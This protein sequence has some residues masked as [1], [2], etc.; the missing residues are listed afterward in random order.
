MKPVT[1]LDTV[2]WSR[3]GTIGGTILSLVMTLMSH[4]SHTAILTKTAADTSMNWNIVNVEMYTGIGMAL[5][6][7]V[8]AWRATTGMT[9]VQI[10]TP[11]Q[12]AS[13]PDETS[14]ILMSKLTHRL[15]V[16]AADAIVNSI[17]TGGTR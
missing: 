14:Q 16:E 1:F 7:I 10:N 2:N 12:V 5:V 15:R 11:P 17:N 13:S 9:H 3:I 6:A 8:A 4:F